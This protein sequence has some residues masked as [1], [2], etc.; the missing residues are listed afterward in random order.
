LSWGM[1]M[2]FRLG[3]TSAVGMRQFSPSLLGGRGFSS[4]S[5]VSGKICNLEDGKDGVGILRFDDPSSKV[6]S[7]SADFVSEFVEAVDQFENN[8]NYKALVLISGKKDN[9]IAGADINQLA[10]CKTAED[11][12]KLSRDGKEMLDRLAKNKRPIIAAVNGQCLGGG[13]EVALACHKRIATSKSVL[14][15]PEVML[16]LLPGAGGTQRLPKLVGTPKALEMMLTGKNIQAAKAKKMGLVDVVVDPYALESS[17]LAAAKEMIDGKKSS[18]KKKDLMTRILEM[19]VIRNNVMFEQAKKGVLAKTRGN[20]PAPLAIIDCVKSGFDNGEEAGYSTETRRFGELG[21]TQESKALISLF[22][23]RTACKKNRFGKPERP[24]EKVGMIGAG[25]MGAG[26][27]EVSITKGNMDVYLKDSNNERLS[28]GYNQIYENLNKKVKR[29]SLT[30]FKLE[31]TMSRLHPVPGDQPEADKAFKNVDL[32]IEAIPEDLALKQAVLSDLEKKVPE[33]CVIASNTSQLPIGDIAKS[34]ARPDKLIGMHYFSPVDKMELLEI[35][36]TKDTS[37]E[38]TSIAVDAGLR[39]GKSVIVV[40]DGP[41]FYTTRIL[42]PFMAEFAALLQEGADP[43][44]LD[45]YMKDLGFPV[46]P[47]TL[48]DEVGIDVGNHV[49]HDLTAAFGERMGGADVGLLED[50]VN[51]GFLGRKTGKGFFLYEKKKKTFL[52]KLTGKGNKRE[53]NQEAMSLVAKYRRAGAKEVS[54]EDV[55]YRMLTRM[56]NEAVLCLQEGILHSAVDG[57]FGA[58]FGLGFPPF[59][60]GP[61]RWIDTYGAQNVVNLMNRFKD[62]HGAQFAPCDLLVEKAKSGEKFH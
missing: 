11:L 50:M 26:I 28:R 61:F 44:K 25:L 1:G 37:K 36:T 2:A 19:P 3:R 58:V 52:Q 4:S 7:L 46:G 35:I 53:L 31:Q 21:M 49:S 33:H 16:G 22:H 20:Y 38:T 14:A 23:A 60:G 55:Q 45:S 54:K 12:E 34:I 9:F 47:V 48:I 32:I 62:Q 6:N 59:F 10:G 43:I 40:G 29:K 27:A 17:A 57:D 18:P 56:A 8:P 41:G 30:A 42:A 51:A 5:L 39:Q 13:L 24:A 15:L